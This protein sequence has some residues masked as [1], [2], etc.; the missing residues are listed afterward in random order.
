MKRLEWLPWRSRESWA[1]GSLRPAVQIG[2]GGAIG[3]GLMYLLDAETGRRRRIVVRDRSLATIRRAGRRVEGYRRLAGAAVGGLVQ[4]VIHAPKGHHLAPNDEALADRVR[5]EVFRRQEI[6]AGQV[7]LNVELGVA[8][9]RGQL[10][11]PEQIRK[12]EAAV[13]RVDGVLDVKNYLHL[14]HTPAPNKQ[15]AL[16]TV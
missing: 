16:G 5:S 15:D 7:N 4:R 3:A 8:V 9:L 2:A 14:P 6:P 10:A 11:E 12:V 13:R 1:V